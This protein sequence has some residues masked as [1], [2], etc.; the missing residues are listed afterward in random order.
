MLAPRRSQPIGDEHQR[1][2]A[3]PHGLA[4][5]GPRKPVEYRVEPEFDP[6][7]TRRQHRPPVPRADRAYFIARDA[8]IVRRVTVQE[9]AELAE[10]EMRCQQI[11]TAEIGRCLLLKKHP[12]A[13]RAW[14]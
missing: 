13:N 14:V 4:T 9:T 2:I 12:S 8:A 3:Q 10:I 7:R 5:I 11:A 1:P 6:H